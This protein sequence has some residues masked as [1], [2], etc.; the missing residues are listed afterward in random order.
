MD[1]NSYILGFDFPSVDTTM[2]CGASSGMETIQNSLSSPYQSTPVS[3]EPP[4]S[5]MPPLEK[6]PEK[7]PIT[8]EADN[9]TEVA[10]K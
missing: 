7:V 2:D 1:P 9:I 8:H 4:Y 10:S 5:D 3:S 6:T